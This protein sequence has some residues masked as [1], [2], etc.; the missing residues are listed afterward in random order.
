LAAFPIF[1]PSLTA[2]PCALLVSPVSEEAAAGRTKYRSERAPPAIDE[3]V[4]ERALAAM[5]A[6]ERPRNAWRKLS[7]RDAHG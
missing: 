4:K 3:F 1:R 5:P 2:C 6:P 7:A